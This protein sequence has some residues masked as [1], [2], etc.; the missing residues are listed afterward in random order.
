MKWS[1][2]DLGQVLHSVQKYAQ[3]HNI[4]L[5]TIGAL[6][7]TGLVAYGAGLGAMSYSSQPKSLESAVKVTR[8]VSDRFRLQSQAKST[9]E[10]D[11]QLAEAS[12]AP[13]VT[14]NVEVDGQTIPVPSDG[15]VHK[16]IATDSGTT[17]VD[18]SI[19]SHNTT[20]NNSSQQTTLDISVNSQ[21]TVD[22]GQDEGPF[23][24]DY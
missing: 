3:G 7:A 19:S 21:S 10:V 12:G 9:N 8:S 6:F 13:V 20:S 5:G 18:M 11:G 24:D 17:S 22:Y 16:Q 2:T 1:H 15:E 14:G 23:F 4:H